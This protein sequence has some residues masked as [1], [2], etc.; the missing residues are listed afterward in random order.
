MKSNTFSGAWIGGTAAVVLAGMMLVAGAQSASAAVFPPFP[1]PA[2]LPLSCG[3][4]LIVPP[5]DTPIV[6]GKV[7]SKTATSV[8]VQKHDL[9]LLVVNT[10]STTL[11]VAGMQCVTLADIS[12][13]QWVTSTGSIS[14]GAMTALQIMLWPLGY[15]PLAPLPPPPLLP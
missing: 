10:T 2:P 1:P 6:L 3:R 12:I 5:V 4:S 9:S 11:I 13:G 7:V 8:T 14:S 15:N